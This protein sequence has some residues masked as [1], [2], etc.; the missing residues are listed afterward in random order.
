[1]FSAGREPLEF[2]P[3]AP[4]WYASYTRSRYE[5]QVARELNQRGVESFLPL[6]EQI[7]HWSHDHRKVQLPLFPGYVFVHIPLRNR[8]CVLQIPGVVRLVSV[9]G[10]PA[11]IDDAEIETLRLAL[12]NSAHTEPC[13]Y[14]KLGQQV[15]IESGPLQGLCGKVLRKN[16]HL[17]VVISI[18]LL[19]RSIL[20]DV[21]ANRLAA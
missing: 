21:D 1:M 9:K 12:A 19:M 3:Y 2:S 20:V 5:K 8:L 4:R 16:H 18:D 17:R 6:Y 13:P 7:H 11:P 15:R 14:I 10:E